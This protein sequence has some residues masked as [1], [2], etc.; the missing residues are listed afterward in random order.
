M[1]LIDRTAYDQ[2]T[3]PILGHV[4]NYPE[5]KFSEHIINTISKDTPPE[6]LQYLSDLLSF[7]INHSDFHESA[8]K[9][10][11]YNENFFQGKSFKDLLIAHKTLVDSAL[12]KKNS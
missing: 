5:S 7:H 4:A 1:D 9:M 11:Q 2:G 3:F 6:K 8:D 10:K 12:K